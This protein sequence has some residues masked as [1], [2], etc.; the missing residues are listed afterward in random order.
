[1]ILFRNSRRRCRGHSGTAGDGGRELSDLRAA[2]GANA[3]QL[4]QVGLGTRGR[5]HLDH[6][7]TLHGNCVRIIGLERQC[8]VGH[9]D[10]LAEQMLLFRDPREVDE[11][12]AVARIDGERR[13]EHVLCLLEL[14]GIEQRLALVLELDRFG[15]DLVVRTLARHGRRERDGREAGQ[16]KTRQGTHSLSTSPGRRL[17][18]AG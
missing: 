2:F 1:L 13:L 11:C 17:A 18:R 6:R 9:A 4:L 10:R 15:L 5:T 7:L 14:A 8:L 16:Q 12:P 3:L